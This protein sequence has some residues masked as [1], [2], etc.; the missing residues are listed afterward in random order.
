MEARN[1]ISEPD[2]DDRRA[3]VLRVTERFASVLVESGLPRMP[4]RI[5]AVLLATDSGSLTSAQLCDLLQASPAAISG[6]ARYLI[7]VNMIRRAGEPGSNRHHY[8][9]PEDI[10]DG[11]FKDRD[12]ILERWTAT[13][14]EGVDLLGA[15]TP[16][17]AR[18]AGS[19]DYFEFMS[20]EL[21]KVVAKWQE[22][23]ASL[24][25]DPRLNVGKTGTK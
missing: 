18:M 21:S 25:A 8:Q 14:R 16:A 17:G 3:R 9:I 7:G 12:R 11:V 1:L 10:W 20:A 13:F 5:F 6:G 4:A 24:M 2:T 15:D 23:K 22:H 19:V